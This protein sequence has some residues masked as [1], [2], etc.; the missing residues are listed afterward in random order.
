MHP[1]G[2][3]SPP[4]GGPLPSLRESTRL[5]TGDT[6]QARFRLVAVPACVDDPPHSRLHI[7]T[8]RELLAFHELGASRH[9]HTG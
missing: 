8:A 6:D 4:C 5:R 2:A 7:L 9:D 3:W 1:R